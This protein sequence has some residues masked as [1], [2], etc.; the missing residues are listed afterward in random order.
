MKKYHSPYKAAEVAKRERERKRVGG[1]GPD[2][3]YEP[4]VSEAVRDLLLEKRGVWPNYSRVSLK[5]GIAEARLRH[6][7][8]GEADLKLDDLDRLIHCYGL[9]WLIGDDVEETDTV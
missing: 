5:T 2:D 8:A 6:F 7:V 9:D 3:D 1:I 4:F